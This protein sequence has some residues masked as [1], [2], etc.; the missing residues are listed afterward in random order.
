[1]LVNDAEHVRRVCPKAPRLLAIQ[2]RLV[3]NNS[4]RIC[5][6]APRLITNQT[7]LF[8]CALRK[9]SI[10]S[11]LTPHKRHL[12]PATTHG[13]LFKSAA[14][15]STSATTCYQ[16]LRTPSCPGATLDGT[17]DTACYLRGAK[18]FGVTDFC[19]TCGICYQQL[20]TEL[21]QTA[22]PA[23]TWAASC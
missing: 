12:L 3:I 4:A 5:F 14:L 15:V 19:P 16:Q 8:A 11:M 2:P 20:R 17:S 6:T 18:S 7:P 1:M 13:S 9:L 21:S 22:M 10:S 23:S